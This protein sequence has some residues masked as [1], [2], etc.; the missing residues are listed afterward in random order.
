MKCFGVVVGVGDVGGDELEVEWK[1][2]VGVLVDEDE[3]IGFD[4]EVEIDVVIYE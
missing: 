2:V 3:G 4:V 1:I